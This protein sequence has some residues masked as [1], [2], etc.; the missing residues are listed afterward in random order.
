MMLFVVGVIGLL[1]LGG[2]AW[3]TFIQLIRSFSE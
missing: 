1:V 3:M 2:C